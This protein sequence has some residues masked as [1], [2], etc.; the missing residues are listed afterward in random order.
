MGDS[1]SLTAK[2]LCQKSTA[3]YW[4]IKTNAF[5]SLMPTQLCLSYRGL[6]EHSK[7]P[8][9]GVLLSSRLG[10]Q[11]SVSSA[12]TQAAAINT[13][14]LLSTDKVQYVPRHWKRLQHASNRSRRTKTNND[15]TES[16]GLTTPKGIKAKLFEDPAMQDA[17]HLWSIKSVSLKIRSYAI[18][19]KDNCKLT[20]LLQETKGQTAA[21][22]RG[23]QVFKQQ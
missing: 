20:E 5:Y 9:L 12:D 15:L 23:R 7:P 10:K 3:V 18:Q 21:A 11:A 8:K 16:S 2:S 6:A 14:K 17:Q 22:S 19:R 13:A 1:T 4:V